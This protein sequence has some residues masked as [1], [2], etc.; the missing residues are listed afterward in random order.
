VS[1]QTQSRA[2][3]RRICRRKHSTGR[4][5]C[6]GGSERDGTSVSEPRA[7][8]QNDRD[9]VCRRLREPRHRPGTGQQAHFG[10]NGPDEWAPHDP[11]KPAQGQARAASRRPAAHSR[12]L[13][14]GP[15]TQ[16]GCRC[17]PHRL[18]ALP[19]RARACPSKRPPIARVTAPSRRLRL[20]RL[21]LRRQDRKAG[22][23]RLKRL[24]DEAVSGGS[25]YRAEYAEL[26]LR[27]LWA[28][29]DELA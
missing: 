19:R 15:F 14:V 22:G 11:L 20:A 16:P 2:S 12:D 29:Q 28:E 26:A 24:D 3:S 9:T 8:V 21:R 7:S 5:L 17:L 1:A 23:G 25:D 27:A 18:P 6:R 10:R 13:T 4:F